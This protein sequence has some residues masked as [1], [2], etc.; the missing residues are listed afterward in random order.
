MRYRIIF[1]AK[2]DNDFNWDVNEVYESN[3]LLAIIFQFQLMI[4]REFKTIIEKS[5]MIGVDDDIPF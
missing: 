1:N 2:K 4:T 5:K 3:D